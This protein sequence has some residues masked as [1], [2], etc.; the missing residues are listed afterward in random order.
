MWYWE[1]IKIYLLDHWRLMVHGE[2]ESHWFSEKLFFQWL[3]T[4]MSLL[5]ITKTRLIIKGPGIFHSYS[6]SLRSLHGDF[7]LPSANSALSV[8]RASI[9]DKWVRDPT[10]RQNTWILQSI[11]ILMAD[12]RYITTFSNYSSSWFWL[13]RKWYQ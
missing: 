13:V 2:W 10:A 7:T 3:C 11:K 12:A 8:E 5:F 1:G 6:V 9:L 4:D